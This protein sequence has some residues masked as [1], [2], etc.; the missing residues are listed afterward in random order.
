MKCS[1]F[2]FDLHFSLQVDNMAHLSLKRLNFWTAT[3]G[4]K[5]REKCPNTDFFLVH[6]FPHSDWIWRDTPYLSV[7]SPN[8]GKYGPVKN[9]YLDSFHAVNVST[10]H[11]MYYFSFV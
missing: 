8:A 4:W 9:S 2:I 6:I 1:L 5:I 11:L 3:R 7:F 10:D